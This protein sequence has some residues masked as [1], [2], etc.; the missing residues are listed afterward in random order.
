MAGDWIP[1]RLDLAEDPAVIEMADALGEP[2]AHV[3]GYLHVI[4]SWASRNCHD[5]SVTGV[6]LMSLSRV[7]RTGQVPEL[8]ARVGWLEVTDE[9]GRPTLHFPKWNRWNSQSAKSRVL[10]TNRKRESR[11]ASVPKTSRSERDKNAT[12]EEKRREYIPPPP[13]PSAKRPSGGWVGEPDPEGGGGG[14]SWKGIRTQLAGHGMADPDTAIAGAKGLGMD[15]ERAAN[16]I[17]FWEAQRPRMDVGAL[18]WCFTRGD[19]PTNGR[20]E[21]SGEI[22]REEYDRQRARKQRERDEL[23]KQ[24]RGVGHDEAGLGDDWRKTLNGHQEAES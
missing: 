23:L 22:S 3:V 14:I 4:W 6:T 16:L 1:M 20:G 7:T 19:W 2:E 12:T 18:H 24:G 21:P 15:P 8:M 13:T 9:N 11:H 10:A 5:G 17:G